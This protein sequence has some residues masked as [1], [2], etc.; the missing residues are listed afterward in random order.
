MQHHECIIP[1]LCVIALCILGVF[2]CKAL[3]RQAHTADRWRVEY[4]SKDGATYNPTFAFVRTCH[5]IARRDPSTYIRYAITK[6][7]TGKRLGVWEY[8]PH[9]WDGNGRW[10]KVA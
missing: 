5:K 10:D 3:L 9:V 6:V 2:K 8:S 4:I 1:E 7:A